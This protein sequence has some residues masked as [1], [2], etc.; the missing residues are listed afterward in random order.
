MATKRKGLFYDEDRKRYRV[1]IYHN[2]REFFF[3]Y[4]KD[5]AEAIEAWEEARE[6]RRTAPPEVPS[7][8]LL[9]PSTKNILESLDDNNR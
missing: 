5:E 9:V 2:R 3:G 1:R 7:T 8:P 4:F 6:A